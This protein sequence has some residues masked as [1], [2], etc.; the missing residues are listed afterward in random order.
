MELNSRDLT[1]RIDMLKKVREKAIK[2]LEHTPEGRLRVSHQNNHDR[3]Y[4]VI[5][6]KEKTGKY[7]PESQRT[8]IVALAQK[9]YLSKLVSSID[10]EIKAS[11]YYMK[12]MPKTTAEEVFVR[13]HSAR[14]ELVTPLLESDEE[15]VKRWLTKKYPENPFNPEERCYSTKR[16]EFV[17]SKSEAMIADAYHDL[18]IPYR[19][20][21]PVNVGNRSP[22]F[23]DFA[24]MDVRHRRI[25]YHEHLGRLDDP[26]YLHKN[27]LKLDEY[28][29]VGIFTG[30]NLILTTE[31]EGCPLDMNL[32]RQN[33]AELFGKTP[34]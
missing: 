1:K 2:Q 30:K 8:L 31:L 4:L 15:Y 5:D 19:Y 11:E 25:I 9:G 24:L 26:V 20:E 18:G 32:F 14:K 17:R 16:G 29:R 13:L 6:P 34:V 22:R 27:M 12:V 21:Y 23:A 28:R 10:R 33:T 3:M 7:L